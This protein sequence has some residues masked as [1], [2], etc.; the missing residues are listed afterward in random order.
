MTLVSLSTVLN[1]PGLC[2]NFN[3][4]PALGNWLNTST[5]TQW[6]A[7]VFAAQQDMTVSHVGFRVS[8]ANGSP[9]VEVRI[10]TVD[11]STGNPTGTLWGTNTNATSG[12]ITANSNP[13]VAL[14]ASASITKG[15]LFCVKFVFASGTQIIIQSL[16]QNSVFSNSSLP[17]HV[18]NTGSVV[19]SQF[20]NHTASIALGSSSTT[21]YQVPGT[22]PMSAVGGGTF[23][24]T[25]SAKRGMRF[26]IPMNCR[27][28]GAKLYLAISSGDY[29]A[30]LMSDAGSELSSSST[31]YAGNA[32]A[33]NASGATYVY[34]D[35]AVTLTAGTTYR[36]VVEPSTTTNT[37][38]S[39]FTLPSSSYQGAA[40]GAGAAMYTTFNG[41]WTDSTTEVPVMDLLIDQVDNGSGSG[42]GG[43]RVFGG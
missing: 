24:N 38:L 41:S 43:Q 17:Y 36:L 35:N 12:T 34:F 11:T 15:Q 26:T 16:G 40:P 14:T 3:S 25:S 1:W 30:I 39:T 6:G 4:G 32:N 9:T 13:L 37:S 28:V 5:T 7:Y 42:G 19:K 20:A 29:N 18:L 21:F 27:A 10:E 23:N 2:G 33:V 22:I 8:T 31:A